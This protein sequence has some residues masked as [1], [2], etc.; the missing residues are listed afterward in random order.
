MNPEIL[1]CALGEIDLKYVDEAANYRRARV[2][3]KR[4][5]FVKVFAAA[6]CLVLAVYAAAQFALEGSPAAP[7]ADP[8]LPKIELGDNMF[9]GAGA[10]NMYA[11][12]FSE[13][14]TGN[15]WSEDMGL[16]TLPVY[17][18]AV[19]HASYEQNRVPLNADREAMYALL[20]NLIAA[21][22]YDEGG[23]EVTESYENTMP[24]MEEGVDYLS[25]ITAEGDEAYISVGADMVASI[26]FK[27]PVELPVDFDSTSPEKCAAAGESVSQLFANLLGFENPRVAVSGGDVDY[28]GGRSYS[29]CVYD[30]GEDD[31]GTVVNYNLQSAELYPSEDGGL[32]GI[33]LYRRDLSQ[34]VGDYPL[35]SV[36]EARELLLNGGELPDTLETLSGDDIVGVELIY[37][38]NEYDEYFAP[39]YRFWLR[40]ENESVIEALDGLAAFT[41]YY[42]P[43]IEPQYIE[44]YAPQITIN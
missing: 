1:S 33:L 24:G 19:H 39:Y 30:A 8:N 25:S 23:F 37:Q 16:A 18:N 6:A 12:D 28:N 5:S 9:D 41:W 10:F 44:S 29:V 3:R 2:R 13:Y 26:S 32:G 27:T 7:T 34:K 36:D 31:T 40:V 42:V 15:P 17:A 14:P 35:I 21:L 20:D 22:G 43:A 4:R 11:P 38:A